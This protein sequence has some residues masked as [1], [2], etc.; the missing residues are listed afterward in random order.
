M[1]RYLVYQASGGISHML[2]G[3]SA[4]ISLAKKTKRHLAVDTKSHLGFGKEPK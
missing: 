3:L 4:A 2:S 1:D